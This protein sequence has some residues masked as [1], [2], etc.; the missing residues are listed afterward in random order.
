MI[1]PPS[2]VFGGSFPCSVNSQ[3]QKMSTGRRKGNPFVCSDRIV[4]LSPVRTSAVASEEEKSRAPLAEESSRSSVFIRP[5]LVGPLSV[6]GR[7]GLRG[8][9]S[10]GFFVDKNF[11]APIFL[12]PRRGRVLGDRRVLSVRHS[13]D[14]KRVD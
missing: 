11:D 6:S 5:A 1:F 9:R 8:L 3:L 2:R 14:A 10:Y 7:V 12:S 4:A 13:S